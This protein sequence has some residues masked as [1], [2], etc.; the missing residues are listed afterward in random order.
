MTANILLSSAL[1]GILLWLTNDDSSFEDFADVKENFIIAFFY[2]LT[3]IG[4]FYLA[5]GVLVF[6]GPLVVLL[7]PVTLI[8]FLIW[9]V[10]LAMEK[11]GLGVFGAIF[12]LIASSI[13]Q[14]L[15]LHYGFVFVKGLFA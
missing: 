15:L 11:F 2:N 14:Y 10:R 9:C 13:L 3:V 4:C 7:L 12:V 5:I 8:G 6:T 1:I